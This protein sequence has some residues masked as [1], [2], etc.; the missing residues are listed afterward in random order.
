MTVGVYEYTGGAHGNYWDIAYN[1]DLESGEVYTLKDYY[2]NEQYLQYVDHV[3]QEELVREAD[4]VFVRAAAAEVVVLASG[5]KPLLPDIRG[6]ETSR[7]LF[8]KLCRGLPNKR[9]LEGNQSRIPEK[10]RVYE[11]YHAEGKTGSRDGTD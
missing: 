1:F 9:S 7:S 11:I 5:A 2:Q 8:S 3:I 4:D 10:R 6:L